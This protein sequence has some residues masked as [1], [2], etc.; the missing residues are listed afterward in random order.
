MIVLYRVFQI[1]ELFAIRQKG[2][3]K[4]ASLASTSFTPLSSFYF[5]TCK[6]CIWWKKFIYY[7]SRVLL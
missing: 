1:S 7:K 5:F 6:R 3:Q 4:L 2:A